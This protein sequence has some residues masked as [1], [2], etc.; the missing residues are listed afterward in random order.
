MLSSCQNMEFCKLMIVDNQ[1]FTPWYPLIHKGSLAS[2]VTSK[3][4]SKS[5]AIT[6]NVRFA[7]GIKKKYIP[8][9]LVM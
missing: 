5:F 9:H 2:K 1:I 6:E 7:S 4:L 8:P 3:L